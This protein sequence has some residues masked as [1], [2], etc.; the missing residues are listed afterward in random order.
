[1]SLQ[2]LLLSGMLTI[3]G[4]G[5][6]ACG[7]V[8]DPAVL[9]PLTNLVELNVFGARLVSGNGGGGGGGDGGAAFGAV[10]GGG[11][12]AA[13]LAVLP[14]LQQLQFLG[15]HV[16]AYTWPAAAE[17]SS[18][19]ALVPS[20]TL[21][22]L[23]LSWCALPVGAL[24]HV[25]TPGRLLPQ[26]QCVSTWDKFGFGCEWDQAAVS[27]LVSSC[28]GLR[29]LQGCFWS[30][31][32]IAALTQLSALTAL[33]VTH[34]GV[35]AEDDAALVQAVAVLTNLQSLNVQS[36]SDLELSR[37]VL[38]PLAALKQLKH[39]RWWQRHNFFFS[40]ETK[41]LNRVSVQT[42]AYTQHTH[43]GLGFV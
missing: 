18:Y 41:F 39:L 14:A 28:P 37:D 38:T 26:L 40:C 8:L 6:P 1:M 31:A 11:A 22:K 24:Q 42:A 35:N 9:R 23:D 30:A 25:F 15:L 12:A 34:K 36:V 33:D 17:S 20:S 2:R 4:F 13:L 32:P 3:I 16:T 29:G 5:Q 43:A 7:I 19:S 10:D 27:N 21:T